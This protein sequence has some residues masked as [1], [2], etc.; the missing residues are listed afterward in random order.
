MSLLSTLW[1][2][3]SGLVKLAMKH[4]AGPSLSLM[5]LTPEFAVPRL[6]DSAIGK[7]ILS[8]DEEWNSELGV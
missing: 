2:D 3:Q 1:P 7:A 4:A 8:N 6:R 5:L